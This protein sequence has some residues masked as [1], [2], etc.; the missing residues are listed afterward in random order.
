MPAGAEP[1]GHYLRTY[2]PD[3]S[4]IV[5]QYLLAETPGIRSQIEPD[6]AIMDGGCGVVTVIFNTDTSVVES[7]A[8]NGVA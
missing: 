3:G 8:C 1:V 2:F 5:G 7:V 6:S 4:R